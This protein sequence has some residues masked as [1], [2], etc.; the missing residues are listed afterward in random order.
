M[1]R[2]L[3]VVSKLIIAAGLGLMAWAVV[4]WQWKDPF[5]GLYTHYEQRKLVERYEGRMSSF[6]PVSSH[7]ASSP[8][9]RIAR[10]ARR[11]RSSVAPGE[12]I[13]RIEIPRLG[14]DMI[15]VNGTDPESL[16]RGPGRDERTFMPG[17]GELVYIAGHRTT[18]LA[19]FSEINRLRPGDSV[20]IGLPYATVRYAVTRHV[21]VP[22]NDLSRLQSPGEELL[23]LQACHPRFSATH[24]Y[25]AYARPVSMR[26]TG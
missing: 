8:A 16:K 10:E 5:T 22:A 4:V 23:A 20:T 3:R 21:I 12:P 11:Y 18:Y 6:R 17:E 25:I 2:L 14:I 15:L 24:R 26:V 9:A 7:P 19:P 13:A 1:N